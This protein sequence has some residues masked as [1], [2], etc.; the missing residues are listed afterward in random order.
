[1]FLLSVS[2]LPYKFFPISC[3]Y[4]C[5][6]N[7]LFPETYAANGYYTIIFGGGNLKENIISLLFIIVITQILAFIAVGLLSVL[8][9]KR[10]L[11]KEA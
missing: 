4:V 7:K 8:K 5:A 11:V 10:H 1:M 9:G 3:N 2:F 6:R